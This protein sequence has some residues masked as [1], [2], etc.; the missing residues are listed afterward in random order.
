MTGPVC[1]NRRHPDH[2]HEWRDRCAK[3]VPPRPLVD[4]VVGQT[5]LWG[6]V[7][8]GAAFVAG[9]RAGEWLAVEGR[10]VAEV[11][12]QRAAERWCEALG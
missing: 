3:P 7:G 5:V 2:V 1:V 12:R 8:L 9:W 4:R 10:L 11:A 6:A